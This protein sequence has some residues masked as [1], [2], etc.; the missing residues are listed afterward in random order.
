MG[1]LTSR[2]QDFEMIGPLLRNKFSKY[3]IIQN[4]KEETFIHQVVSAAYTEHW[5]IENLE[6]FYKELFEILEE[7]KFFPRYQRVR[8]NDI[9]EIEFLYNYDIKIQHPLIALFRE[10][11]KGNFLEDDTIVH[12]IRGILEALKFLHSYNIAHCHLSL[13]NIY[14]YNGIMIDGFEFACF[15][16]KECE[17][18]KKRINSKYSSP[19]MIN[20]TTFD[21]PELLIPSDIWAVGIIF[22]ALVTGN[23]PSRPFD[24]LNPEFGTFRCDNKK[25]EE[26]INGALEK[27]VEKRPSVDKLLNI[28]DDLN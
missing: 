6:N 20:G 1:N 23:F 5:D 14:F 13:L 19:E 15:A 22:R 11:K 21:H 3:W 7:S 17:F 28:F 8:W 16:T 18:S 10:T 9:N 26:I 25:I 4:K 24:A 27:D 2:K 12:I